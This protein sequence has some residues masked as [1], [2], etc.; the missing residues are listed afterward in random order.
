LA[1]LLRG[2]Q[3]REGGVD[4]LA[5][6]LR[7]RVTAAGGE[8]LESPEEDEPL[9]IEELRMEGGRMISAKLEGSPH[10][11]R[12]SFFVAATGA[13]EL[14]DLLPAS[15]SDGKLA[16]LLGGVKTRSAFLT[17]NLVVDIRGI[18]PGLGPAALCVPAKADA[19]SVFL[20][21]FQ[22]Q[23]LAGK[24]VTEA[25]VVQL[26]RQVPT[27]LFH[28]GEG[29]VKAILHEMRTVASDY[30]P[31]LDRHVL[32][33]SSP[34]L[35]EER[36]LASRLRLHPLVEVGLPRQLGVTGLPPRPPCKNLVLASRDVLPGLG[37]EGE[38]LAGV[39]AAEIIQ[40]ELP[41]M[42]ILK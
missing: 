11:Y 6:E 32:L 35:Q 14:R 15:A 19:P 2:L 22:A 40:K 33:E 28:Q 8:V 1:Q 42:A 24:T 39:R 5:A 36:G 10:E 21:L 18:P 38:F 7:H 31:F 26:T 37:I 23:P 4:G 25:R 20:E 30:L 3:R 29:H 16:G 13:A 34:H 41:K 12:A 17:L 9:E 27:H